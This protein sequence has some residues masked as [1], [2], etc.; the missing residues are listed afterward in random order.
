LKWKR[1]RPTTTFEKVFRDV[2]SYTFL[3][4]GTIAAAAG[5]NYIADQHG[6]SLAQ[7]L[8]GGAAFVFVLLFLLFVYM[9][10]DTERGTGPTDWVD[11]ALFHYAALFLSALVA[12]LLTKIVFTVIRLG[13]GALPAVV[14]VYEL[15]RD[16][17]GKSWLIAATALITV[18]LGAGFFVFRL[19]QR[20]LYG[21]TEALAGAAVAAHRVSLEPGTALPS[22]TGFYFAVLTAGVYLVVRG[23][24]NMHQAVLNRDRFVVWITSGPLMRPRS[25][26]S[27][28]ARPAK[29]G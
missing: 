12:T 23:L 6:G 5:M 26:S 27:N 7:A 20:F 16:L 14:N 22:E 1:L 24:D 11:V 21:A 3:T 17:S 2:L 19:R 4:A 15:L 29:A 8:R 9:R 28:R 25:R 13:Q 18:L 10:F